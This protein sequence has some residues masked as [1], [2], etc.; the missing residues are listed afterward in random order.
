MITVKFSCE[1][2]T[3]NPSAPLG[4]ILRA[5]GVE[6]FRQDHVK[7]NQMVEV[8]LDDTERELPHT[9]QFEMFGKNKT[10]TVLDQNNEIIQDACILVQNIFFDD[11]A[12][13]FI[14]SKLGVY[15]HNFNGT[16]DYVEDK[17]WGTMGCNGTVSFEY[18]T[19]SYVW[20]LENL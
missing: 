8:E 1:I 15:L 17:F 18:T 10:H 3:T 19:P 9:L 11:I 20:L 4:F 6:V 14:V 7:Q 12:V 13:D 5:D 2:S 16:K